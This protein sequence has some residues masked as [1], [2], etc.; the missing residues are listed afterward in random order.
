MDSD[1][2]D[3]AANAGD[4][5]T[6]VAVQ[7]NFYEAKAIYK[8]KPMEAL[9]KFE[10]VVMLANPNIDLKD[11]EFWATK[12]QVI[13]NMFLGDFDKMGVAT[14]NLLKLSSK[15]A[16]NETSEAMNEILDAI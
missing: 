14:K 9:E 3:A 10:T 5:D 2:A 1:E 6:D 11:Y 13:I 4:D 15:V 16:K 8:D 12:Y 7:N